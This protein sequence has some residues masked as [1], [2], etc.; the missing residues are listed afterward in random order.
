MLSLIGDLVPK[1]NSNLAS[2]VVWGIGS[3]GGGAI[4]PVVVGFLAGFIGL[5]SS[6]LSVAILG[7][8]SGLLVYFIP[9]SEKRTK[10]P[11]FK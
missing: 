8:I 5:S 4:G 1:G 2:G 7:F 10:T 9:K 3:S 11:M 6:L